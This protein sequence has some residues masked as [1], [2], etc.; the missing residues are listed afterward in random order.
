MGTTGFGEGE[1]ISPLGARR[2]TQA[3]TVV[4]RSQTTVLDSKK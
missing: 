4:P 3:R 2:K 1:M